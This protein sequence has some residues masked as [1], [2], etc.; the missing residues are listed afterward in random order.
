MGGMEGPTDSSP[1]GLTA[2]LRPATQGSRCAATLGYVMEPLRG[3]PD[4]PLSEQ[5]GQVLSSPTCPF[6]HP[7]QQELQTLRNA[8]GQSELWKIVGHF[9]PDIDSM[10]HGN[11]RSRAMAGG[12]SL[13]QLF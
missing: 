1:A 11:L 10:R 13:S 5:T 4:G 8:V 9:H 3:S 12:A 7:L 2:S 6:F